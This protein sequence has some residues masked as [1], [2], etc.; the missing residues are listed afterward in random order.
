MIGVQRRHCSYDAVM[1]VKVAVDPGSCATY[2]SEGFS[3]VRPSDGKG[4][5][6]ERVT[7][8]SKCM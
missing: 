2:N 1:C 3:F 7:D 5:Y 8:E 6:G 4:H